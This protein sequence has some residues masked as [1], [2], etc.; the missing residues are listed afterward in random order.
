MEWTAHGV[1]Q[2]HLQLNLTENHGVDRPWSGPVHFEVVHSMVTYPK[3]YLGRWSTPWSL[4]HFEMEICK[5][6]L[7][8]LTLTKN[9]FRRSQ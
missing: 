7:L 1:D 2:A 5:I 6:T 3:P 9:Y 8:A 4:V